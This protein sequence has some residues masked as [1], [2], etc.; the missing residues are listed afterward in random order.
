MKK[1]IQKMRVTAL[2]AC[3]SLSFVSVQAQNA[4]FNRA[5]LS[6]IEKSKS[7]QT[8]DD[9][10]DLANSFARIAETEK[11]EWT[12][13]YYA[14]LYNLTVN[15]LDPDFDRKEK[16]IA[17]AQKQIEAGLK[18]KPE[19]TELYVLKVM[20]YYGELSI[21]PMLGM[22]LMGEVNALLSQAKSINPD[23]P[24]IYLEEAEAVYNMPVE[25]G[26]GPEKAIPLLLVAKEKFDKFVP[27]NQLAP[28]WG[29][30]RCEQLLQKA[31]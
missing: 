2:C 31:K 26:G 16:F 18:I 20:S 29:K 22:T 5:M 15:F 1:L 14:A 12:A 30:E 9:F 17:L 10:Q 8:L 27:S 4:D 24:R 11:N 13:W 23:N 7:A 28:D 3:I 21:D 6:S 25:Y 19:E